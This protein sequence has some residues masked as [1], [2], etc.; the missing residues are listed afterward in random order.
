MCANWTSGNFLALLPDLAVT[1]IVCAYNL[2]LSSNAKYSCNSSAWNHSQ[3]LHWDWIAQA[4]TKEYVH[5]SHL[6]IPHVYPSIYCMNLWGFALLWRIQVTWC[7][8]CITTPG[9]CWWGT[10]WQTVGP[11]SHVETAP[12][13]WSFAQGYSHNIEHG[14][15]TYK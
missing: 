4:N 13:W 10:W 8:M 3:T 1:W 14:A 9:N 5:K 2:S 7:Y 15:N 12:R 11:Q 6:D